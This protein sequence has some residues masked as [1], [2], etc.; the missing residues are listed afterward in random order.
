MNLIM[1]K[2]IITLAG[3]PGSGK[4]STADK[5]AKEL[6][7]QRFSSGDFMRKIALDMSISL[8]EL[9]TL[10]E[11]DTS[12]DEK[13][14]AEV[15]KAREMNNAV[16]DSRL[17]Y[18][19]IPESFKVYLSLPANIAKERILSNLKTNKL[20]QESEGISNVEE[21]YKKITHRMESE[22]KRYKELYNIDHTDK[23]NFDLVIDTNENNL[24]KVVETI[25]KEYENWQNKKD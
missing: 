5:L 15:Q 10:A 20:R 7:Y 3:A 14:D 9:S 17:A 23:N 11:T 25:L 24:N 13:I 12:I 8:N 6:N 16:I 2:Q 21:I 22:K 1:K 19:W 4:S 18:H